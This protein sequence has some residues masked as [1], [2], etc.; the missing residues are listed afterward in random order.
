MSQ[1]SQQ[2]SD[3]LRESQDR[4]R[5]PCKNKIYF[6]DILTDVKRIDLFP[7]AV[8]PPRGIQ[9]HFYQKLAT[10]KH[11][12]EA[13][14]VLVPHEWQ[15]IRRNQEYLIHLRELSNG[16]PILIFNTGDV[17]PP[18]NLKNAIQIRT[19]LHPG[20]SNQGKIVIP[21]P[22]LGRDFKI[23]D[24]NKTPRVGFM[25]Q[26]PRISPGSLISR[27]KPSFRFPIKSSSY[28]NRRL[29]IAKLRKLG[30]EVNV[31]LVIRPAFTAHHK[32]KNLVAH[33]A[34]F[35]NQLFECDYI[36]CPRGYGNTSI[37]FYESLSAGKTPILVESEGGMPEL[38]EDQEWRNH[39]LSVNFKSKWTEI[40]LQDWMTLSKGDNYLNRQLSNRE[41][42]NSILDFES[43]M[44]HLF[45]DY[46][47]DGENE[48][49]TEYS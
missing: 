45:S 23:R 34:E 36:L 31:D 43:Y 35:Q 41:L 20:E 13:N 1:I 15:D 30:P 6:S 12:D 28:L 9:S 4:H 3:I 29:S 32:N 21:Y 24:W 14:L 11:F 44:T 10:T 17:S 40:I 48:S 39:I 16:A 42:F 49:G 26:L 27:P 22:V 5:E 38:A 8:V 25:G 2:L 18:V 47:E 7:K 46:I 19:F 33:S 37:R